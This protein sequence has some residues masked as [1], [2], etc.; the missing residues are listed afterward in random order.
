MRIT[1]L[2]IKL[3][4]STL[5]DFNESANANGGV[6]Q[7]ARAFGSYPKGRG[8]DPLRRYHVWTRSSVGQS[9]RLITGWSQVRILPGPPIKSFMEEYPS[10]AEG[11][12][13]ENRQGGKPSRGFESLFLRHIFSH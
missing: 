11:I 1:L 3:V 7:L 6:A 9:C 2:L 4:G 13:L 5:L 12:G 8:F 10:L